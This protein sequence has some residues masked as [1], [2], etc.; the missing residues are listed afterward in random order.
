VIVERW[1]FATK[2]GD[3]WEKM[4]ELLKAECERTGEFEFYT[5][6]IGA[7]QAFFAR[8]TVRESV[9]A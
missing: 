5:C 8:A 2:G 4:L 7:R 9:R 6:S 3:C 1:M